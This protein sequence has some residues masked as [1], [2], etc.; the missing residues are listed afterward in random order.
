MQTWRLIQDGPQDGAWNMAVDRAVLAARAAGEAPPTLRLYSWHVPTVTLGRFQSLDDVDMQYCSK[1]GFDVVRRPTG[2]RGVL[3]DDE[4]TYSV[5]A[6][7]EDGMPRGVSASYRLLCGALAE[8]YSLLGV[9]AVLTGRARGEKAAG[10]CYL[11]ATH[12]DL[13]LGAAKLSGSAQ[14]WDHHAVL[15]HGSFVRTRDVEAESRVFKLGE[16]GGKRLRAETATL[17]SAPGGPPTTAAITSAICEA[18]EMSLQI[19][20]KPGVLSAAE[21][22]AAESLRESFNRAE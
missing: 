4:V 19:E 14:V 2:G 11:H 10:A 5:T 13:S 16:L 20:L 12:A 17:E 21:I 15:Q 8:A 6:S 18:F 3:H 22:Q 7:L 1:H 9:P